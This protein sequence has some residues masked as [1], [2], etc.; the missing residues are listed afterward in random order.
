[1]MKYVRMKFLRNKNPSSDFIKETFENERKKSTQIQKNNIAS[2][3]QI[4]NNK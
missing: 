1:M 4:Q 3:Q 2:N